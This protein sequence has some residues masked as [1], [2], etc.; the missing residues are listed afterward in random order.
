MSSSSIERSSG[1]A[2]MGAGFLTVVVNCVFSLLLPR[3]VSYAQTAASSSFAWREA[4]AVICAALLLFGTIGLYLR[5]QDKSGKLGAAAFA[6]AFYGSALLLGIEWSQRFDIHD[7]AFRA[8]EALN[9]LNSARG[10]HL[11]DIGGLI[12]LAVFTTG[13]LALAAITIWTRVPSREAGILVVLGTFLPFLTPL[14]R[15]ILPGLAAPIIGNVILAGGFGWLGF[16]L[17]RT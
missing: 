1:L 11:T 12:V 17:W 14:L 13:W 16:A 6:L 9:V 4:L 15:P 8:P 3:G 10:L 5:Q 7:F 2:L